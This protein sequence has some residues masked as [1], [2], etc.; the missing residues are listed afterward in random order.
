MPYA[1]LKGGLL[2]GVA[3][4]VVVALLSGY[5][6]RLLLRVKNAL[7]ADGDVVSS[8]SFG[9]ITS[10]VLGRWGEITVNVFLVFTQCGFA[11]AYVIFIS[12]NL[13]HL[14]P[15]LSYLQWTAVTFVA[16]AA[17]CLPRQ[18]KKL[19]PVSLAGFVVELAAVIYVIAYAFRDKDV[20]L[21][22][23]KLVHV[24]VDT[25]PIYFGIAIYVFEGIGLVV[26]MEK[27]MRHP[28][29]YEKLLWSAYA[30][31]IVLVVSLGW[32]GVLGF[33]SDTKSIVV[34]NLPKHWVATKL[35][36]VALMVALYS[37]V[38]VQLFPV[39]SLAEN[40][41]FRVSTRHL[42]LKR[43]VMRIAL[44]AVVCFVAVGIPHF[45]LFMGIVGGLGSSMLA[46]QLP[47]VAYCVYFWDGKRDRTLHVAEIIACGAITVFGVF[48]AVISTYVTIHA[49]VKGDDN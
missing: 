11:C 36:T 8:R 19:A 31:I 4:L 22:R 45:G 47:A 33:G 35:I 44:V 25:L 48:G 30:V 24:P 9:S 27:S 43:S 17:I 1:F 10:R 2:S 34:L 18:F 46:F 23:E 16:H 7:V 29:H 41:L 32:V 15:T 39:I 28:Q 6:V 37:S 20:S 49:L 21:T 40:R 14:V 12:T 5:G 13:H 26:D 3:T 38:P 42:E